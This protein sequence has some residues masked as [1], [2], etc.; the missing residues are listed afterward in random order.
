MEAKQRKA[1]SKRQRVDRVLEAESRAAILDAAKVVQTLLGVVIDE[2]AGENN[3]IKVV[4][5][6]LPTPVRT[7]HR[8]KA[9]G[10]GVFAH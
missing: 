9:C 10:S 4:T 8:Q 5:H 2:Y 6:Q 1:T 7:C 3:L